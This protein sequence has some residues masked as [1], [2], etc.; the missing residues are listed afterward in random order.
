MG[1]NHLSAADY[2]RLAA[3]MAG[4]HG[5]PVSTESP[6]DFL[7]VFSC[8]DPRVGHEAASLYARGLVRNV[9]F[10]G[11]VGKYS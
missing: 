11:A 3:V 7:I 1:E 8:A 5:Q 6:A 4:P 10:S 9:V 2:D